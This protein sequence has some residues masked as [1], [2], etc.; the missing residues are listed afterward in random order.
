MNTTDKFININED[1]N[2]YWK[3][4]TNALTVYAWAL[5]F[6]KNLEG[7]SLQ[8]TSPKAATLVRASH[9]TGDKIIKELTDAGL[10]VLIGKD[11]TAANVFSVVD[12]EK[13][14]ELALKTEEEYATYLQQFEKRTKRNK[15]RREQHHASK[16]KANAK[17]IINNEQQDTQNCIP[18]VSNISDV[19][20]LPQPIEQ[21]NEPEQAS[22]TTP[23]PAEVVQTAP[24]SIWESSFTPVTNAS[25]LISAL[26]GDDQQQELDEFGST[27]QRN[28]YEPF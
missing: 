16:G 24:F 27:I 1:L 10:L 23:H 20:E 22:E 26:F 6:Y 14:P 12:W 19:A 17:A 9:G 8:L 18:D 5:R 7:K 25:D 11:E 13:H 15:E 3:H 4:S 21:V 2:T 28:E